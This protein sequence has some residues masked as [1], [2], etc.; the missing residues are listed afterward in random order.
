MCLSPAHAARVMI[1][2][3]QR[4]SHLDRSLREEATKPG[5]LAHPSMLA[6]RVSVARTFL[7]VRSA[8]PCSSRALSVSAMAAAYPKLK[9]VYFNIKARAEPTRLALHIAGIPFE[10][11][12]IAHEEWP[13]LKATMPLGQ[14]PVSSA[15]PPAAAPQRAASQQLAARAASWRVLARC[16]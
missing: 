11:K 12:R 8:R 10:D 5:P 13:A 4:V 2:L 9:L 14:I 15:Q 1:T 6:S 16:N 3:A 7:R